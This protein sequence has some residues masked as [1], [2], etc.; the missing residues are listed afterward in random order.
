RNCH[1]NRYSR[2]APERALATRPTEPP[3]S[4]LAI[5]LSL[6]LSLSTLAHAE[7]VIILDPYFYRAPLSD[8]IDGSSKTVLAYYDETDGKVTP[9]P[10]PPRQ[11][12]S[13]LRT[14]AIAYAE[15][16][17]KKA[18]PKFLRDKHGVAVAIRIEN[19]DPAFS[20]ILLTPGFADRFAEILGKDCLVSVP[21]RQ[22]IFL[23]PRLAINMEEFSAPL[24]AIYHNSVWPVSTE[25]FEWRA[26]ALHSVRDFEAK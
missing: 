16:I 15:A 20:S 5:L 26:G 1:S 23:F 21:N 9:F 7:P 8:P 22:T 13:E 3:H 17:L 4:L 10:N 25:L 14:L 11:A 12:V 18:T 24:L 6:F 2:V 19:P